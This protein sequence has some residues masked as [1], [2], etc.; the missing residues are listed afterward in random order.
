MLGVMATCIGNY[1][2]TVAGE[3]HYEAGHKELYDVGHILLPQ[4]PVSTPVFTIVEWAWVPFLLAARPSLAQAASFH[5]AI[6]FGAL[7]ALRAIANTVTV[8]PKDDSCK[9]TKWTLRNFLAGACYDKLFS[10]HLAYATL[11]GL[12]MVRFGMWPTW[13]GWLYGSIMATLMLFSRGH[14]TVDLVLGIALAY[15]TWTSSLFPSP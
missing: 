4:I 6:R 7:L 1:A 15:L 9:T 2:A 13:G 11:V 5:V 8:L 3:R 12:A 14:Y 10:G